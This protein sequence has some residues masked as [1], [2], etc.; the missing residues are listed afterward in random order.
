M[1]ALFFGLL[2]LSNQLV[3]SE[4][5]ILLVAKS[6]SISN[7]ELERNKNDIRVYTNQ[8]IGSKI[9][10]FKA[11]T[12]VSCEMSSL[13]SLIEHVEQ[14]P[15]WQSDIST[16]KGVTELKNDSCFIFLTSK[17][18]WPFT[19]RC[20]SLLVVKSVSNSRVVNYNLSNSPVKLIKKDFVQVTSVK[21]IWQ[22]IPKESGEI[23]VIFQFYGDP[24]GNIPI[25]LLNTLIVDGPYQTLMNL[26]RLV[27]N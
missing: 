16:A 5:T 21:G 14:Y 22:F 23:D 20:M 19:D 10:G 24:G 2:M 13:I 6:E 7:W 1:K 18:P 8:P 27:E 3:N 15:S 4:K 9:K 12:T 25:W 17:M 26:R 11:I